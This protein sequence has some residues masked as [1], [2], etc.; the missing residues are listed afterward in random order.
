MNKGKVRM[1]G[2]GMYYVTNDKTKLLG[3]S[4]SGSRYG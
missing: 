1:D 2:Q 3:G 4:R